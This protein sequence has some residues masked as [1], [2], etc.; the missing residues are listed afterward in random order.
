MSK[1]S[2]APADTAAAAD[3]PVSRFESSLGELE[4]IVARMERGELSLE[5]SLTLFERG[6]QLTQECRGSLD[7]AELRVKN[8]LDA[9]RADAAEPD[10]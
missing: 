5:E 9:R 8:L 7:R 6:M 2:P 3:D 1:K 10:A 4:G